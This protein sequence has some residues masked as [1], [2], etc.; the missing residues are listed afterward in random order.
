MNALEA[1]SQA[2][3]VMTVRRVYGEPYQ[4]DG[5]TIIPAANV[6]GGGGISLVNYG[7]T[8]SVAIGAGATVSGGADGISV[9]NSGTGPIAITVAATGT[10]SGS[11]GLGIRASGSAATSST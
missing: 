3:D 9:S 2:K 1:V 4:Q 6:T 7:T 8:V 5:V 11:S 10:V